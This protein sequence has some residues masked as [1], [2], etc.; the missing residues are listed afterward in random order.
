MVLIINAKD[1]YSDTPLYEAAYAE[2]LDVAEFLIKHTLLQDPSAAQL[3]FSQEKL[4][5]YWIKCKEELIKLEQ[6]NP[7]LFNFL[8]ANS[9]KEGVKIWAQNKSILK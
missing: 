6:E 5:T 2:R 1:K 9:F 7:R 8:Y 3:N 4:K